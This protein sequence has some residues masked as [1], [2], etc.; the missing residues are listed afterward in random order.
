MMMD[1]SESLPVDALL[2]P[3]PTP[4][5]ELAR[6]LGALVRATVP[7]SIERVR[8]GWHVI[9]Y[10][11][12]IG[13]GWTAFFAWVMPQREHVHL[14]FPRGVLLGDPRGVLEG[15]GITKLARW[16]TAARPEDI[17]VEEFSSLVREAIAVAHVPRSVGLAG[18]RVETGR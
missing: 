15:A 18:I 7:D 14:G 17:D 10:D 16:V 5:P 12:P 11:V 4:M 9:G 6:S 8:A 2:A 3:L 1:P 13:R